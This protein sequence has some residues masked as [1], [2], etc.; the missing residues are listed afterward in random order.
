MKFFRAVS[1][2]SGM[3][4]AGSVIVRDL[5]IDTH[6]DLPAEPLV[7]DKEGILLGLVSA[8]RAVIVVKRYTFQTKMFANLGKTSNTEE[9]GALQSDRDVR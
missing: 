7:H 4:Q 6:F 5:N 3:V 8:S 1:T 9:M 2:L